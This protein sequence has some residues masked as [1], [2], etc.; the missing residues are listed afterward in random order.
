MDLKAGK[1]QTLGKR[2]G[3]EFF[4]LSAEKLAP[5]L[6]GKVLVRVW[7]NECLAGMICETEAYTEDDPASHTFRGMTPRNR[8]MFAV[9][10]TMYV[11]QSYGIHWCLNIKS[12]TQGR[13]EGVLIRALQP[14]YGVETMRK[15][16]HLPPSKP[17][18]E[19]CNGPGKLTQA[20]AIDKRFDGQEINRGSIFLYEPSD[21]ALEQS[22]LARGPRIG[23][24]QG[25]DLMWRFALKKHPCLSKPF[26]NVRN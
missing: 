9:P 2:L 23:I 3:P 7:E 16:R 14:L 20:M 13:G 18:H 12:G 11:Y 24:S 5:Q 8:S 6:L 1:I 17:E 21:A 19:L 25:L 22:A 15:L 10:G 26:P 4:T